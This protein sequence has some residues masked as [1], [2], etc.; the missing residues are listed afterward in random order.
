MKKILLFLVIII[1]ISTLGSCGPKDD[2]NPECTSNQELVGG[3]CT[4][5]D[6]GN[7]DA[8]VISGVSEVELTVGDTFNQL[9]GVTAVDEVDG[10]VTADIN[11][12]GD[13][14]LATVGN[15]TLTYTVTDLDG[16]TN[17]VERTIIVVS[18]AGCAI[19]QELIDDECIDIPAEVITI[20]HGAVHEIDPFHELYSGTEQLEKQELIT[21]VEERLNVDVVFKEYPPS[22]AWGPSRI[23]AIIQSS[24]S[25]DHLSDIYW[26]TSDWVQQLVDGDAIASVSSYINEH[27][28]NIDESYLEVGS[29]Q[30]NIYAF[31]VGKVQISNGLYYNADLIDSLGVENPTDLY[32][33]GD[34]NWTKFETWSTN[35][36]T[37]LSAQGD[38]MF[39]LGGILSYYAEN[40]IPLNGGSLINAV[41]GRVSF[42]QNPALE[43]YDYLNNLYDKG[44][45]ELSPQYDAGSPEWMA[46]KIAM[47]PGSLWFVTASNRWGGLPFELG[48]V[49]YPAADSYTGEYVSPVNGV[50]TMAVATGMDP[51]REE[52]VFQVWNEIQLWK[53]DSELAD[54]FELT[55]LTKFDEE[56]YIEAYLEIYD[57]TYLELITSIGI[58]SF[59]GDSWNTNI[60]TAIREGSSRTAVDRIKP[61]YQTAL[62]DYLGN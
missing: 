15:Y 18:T 51:V 16:N 21:E 29:Y 6:Q 12:T 14:D 17:S 45:F 61:I 10:D 13:L 3:K 33:S 44:L 39:S 24:V 23:T 31:E 25:G 9:E 42:A 11:V 54:D 2:N 37:Q 49:P 46:G 5:I 47:H 52:L 1:F 19:Y 56:I 48:F 34:W 53:T 57:K 60:I 35:V 50:A 40:M 30:D 59:G 55:L 27:G 4:D 41:T 8:P 20:M 62:D 7:E 28:T 36:Q 58:G 22:A 38:D 26:I 43:T 32:L